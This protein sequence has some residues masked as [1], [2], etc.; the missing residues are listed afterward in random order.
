MELKH[1]TK[2]WNCSEQYPPDE[3]TTVILRV[4]T[5]KN[6]GKVTDE[7]DKFKIS[8]IGNYLCVK[9]L[10]NNKLLPKYL[11]YSLQHVYNQGYWQRHSYGTSDRNLIRVGDV[12]GIQVGIG[13]E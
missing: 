1:L 2:V 7:K 4:G 10:D 11:Y 5:K 6:V 3:D 12:R 13:D 9:P 8:P